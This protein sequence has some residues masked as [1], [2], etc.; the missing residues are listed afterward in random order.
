MDYK[1]KAIDRHTLRMLAKIIRKIFKSRSRFKFNVIKAFEEIHSIFPN[2]TV[3]IV[4]EDWMKVPARCIPDLNGSYHIEVKESI[5]DGACNGV[6]GF[7]AHILHEM[8]HAML[9]ML[10]Y[11]PILSREFKNNELRAYESM[12]W[13]A[14]ALCGEILC[15][16][17][18]TIGMSVEEIIKKCNVSRDCALIRTKLK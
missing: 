5:Y 2:I 15:P 10:G 3:E 11:T 12:E 16:Y 18:T 7:R 6:G 13:Q 4:E 1:T 17:E 14:K 8:C 9:G